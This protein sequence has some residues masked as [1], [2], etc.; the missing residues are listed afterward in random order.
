V[1]RTLFVVVALAL[2]WG[3]A[4]QSTLYAAC[5][6]LA[7]AYFR[8]EAWAWSDIFASLN[9]SYF[10]G[11]YLVLR[12]VLSGTPFRFD[13][14]SALLIL[15]LAQSL[16]STMFG[17]DPAYSFTFWW[18]FAKTIVVSII[19]T[20]VIRTQADLRLVLI[21]IAVSLGFEAVKQGW[22]QMI[23]NPGAP[24]HNSVPFLGDNN[25]VAVG[26]A[27]LI[28]IITVLGNTSTG[29]VKRGFQFANVG[30]VYRALST[31]SRGGFLSLM[32][33]ASL[34]VWRSKHR[35]KTIAALAVVIALIVPVL[36]AEFWDRMSTI[37]ASA[38]ERDSSTQSRLHFWQVAIAMV[39]DRPLLGVG[40]SAYSRAYNRYDWTEGEFMTNRAVHSA[41]FGVLAELG[42]P[43][44]ILFIAIILSSLY[45]CR[46]VRKAAARGLVPASIGPY[47]IALESSLV[48]FIVGGSFVSFHYC[49]MLWHFF[50]LTIALER[51]AVTEAATEKVGAARPP[52]APAAREPD[53]DFVW[54]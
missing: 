12:T 52:V 24:N 41:W 47:A 34:I 7:I 28:P 26:M 9:L 33:I 44:L 19:L 6:Y 8:P 4:L 1:L 48:A 49:E 45:T 31:Y 30:V 2:G 35:A 53:Q 50:A 38:E 5:L 17:I 11:A 37:T 15:F 20:L 22:A 51:V 32:A 36:P 3:F 29:W 18:A 39:D 42:Y 40:H 14:R 46:R 27:M 10:A 25:L 54:A 23:L 16:I 13:W 43:G 21:V